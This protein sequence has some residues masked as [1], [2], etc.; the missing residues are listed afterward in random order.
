QIDRDAYRIASGA[1]AGGLAG[2]LTRTASGAGI[3]LAIG[4]GLGLAK[5]L[6]TRGDEIYLPEGTNVEMG[7]NQPVTVAQP[8][9]LASIL[10][11]RPKL[12]Y[13]C[14]PEQVRRSRTQAQDLVVSLARNPRTYLDNSRASPRSRK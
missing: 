1:I 8:G 7:I 10:R 14:H 12:S 4:G 2:A 5:S 11:L 3:G 13:I 6:F 9:L